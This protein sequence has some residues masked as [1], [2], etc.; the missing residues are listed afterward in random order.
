VGDLSRHRV[1]LVFAGDAATGELELGCHRKPA[2]DDLDAD[3]PALR[4]VGLLRCAHAS[5][6]EAL[7]AKGRLQRR[8][9]EDPVDTVANLVGLQ[10]RGHVEI[11]VLRVARA[12]EEKA[13]VCPSL[14]DEGSLVGRGS[15]A[16][17][18]GQ[19]E[20]LDRIAVGDGTNRNHGS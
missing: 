6:R 8:S 10:P 4:G 18:K 1:E 17:E 20:Y 14:D 9:A 5:D 3:L 13:Q 15:E 2:T 7:S 12:T 19:V 16:R 11:H